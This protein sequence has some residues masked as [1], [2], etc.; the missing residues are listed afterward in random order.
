MEAMEYQMGVPARH[1]DARPGSGRAV[2]R[3]APVLGRF[4]L[5]R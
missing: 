2:E 3:S 1:E 5:T 4:G